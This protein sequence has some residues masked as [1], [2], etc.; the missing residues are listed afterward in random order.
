MPVGLQLLFDF[1]IRARFA[2]EAANLPIKY[3]G[4]LWAT[5]RAYQHDERLKTEI[6]ELLNELYAVCGWKSRLA[7]PIVGR[8]LY[9]K[10]QQEQQR[11]ADGWTYE[12]PTFYETNFPAQASRAV[13]VQGVV[14]RLQPSDQLTLSSSYETVSARA[15]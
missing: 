8:Y 6:T 14:A 3:A 12:P 1:S 10:L 4:V 5:R 9:R 11:L 7:A 15:G 13:Y 2:H